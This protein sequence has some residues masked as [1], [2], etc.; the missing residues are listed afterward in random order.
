MDVLNVRKATF[1]KQLE[2]T[3][4]KRG[5]IVVVTGPSAS[6]KTTTCQGLE[7][8]GFWRRLVTVTTRPPRKGEIPGWDY[9]FL[10]SEEYDQALVRGLLGEQ[11]VY[12]GNR[13]RYGI[14]QHD[15]DA[16][17][18]MPI[19]YVILDA[20]GRSEIKRIWSEHGLGDRVFS[21]FMAAPKKVLA[22]RLYRRGL[23][24][25][26]SEAEIR[27]EMERRLASYEA[28]MA[29]NRAYDATLWTH[30]ASVPEVIETMKRL[31]TDWIRSFEA[32]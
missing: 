18:N 24:K 3:G 31:V 23:E 4:G 9:H 16:A 21:V 1:A 17:M 15:L 12:A 7:E 32:A 19:S 10:S 11:T 6:G 13:T 8:Q 22:E 5:F 28:E 2:L 29:T 27:A 25:G 14:F 30:E 26:D 20:H